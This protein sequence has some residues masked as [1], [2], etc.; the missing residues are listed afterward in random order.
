MQR[1]KGLEPK[2][3]RAFTLIELLVVIAIIAIL[4]AILFPVFAQARAKAR[5][6]SCLSNLRQIGTATNMYVQDYD[7][8]LPAGWGQ[9]GDPNVPD[10][11]QVW[12]V[13]LQPYIQ[14]VAGGNKDVYAGTKSASIFRCPDQQTEAPTNYGYNTDELVTGWNETSPGSGKWNSSGKA[15]AALNRPANLVAYADSGGEINKQPQSLSAD[16]NIRQGGGICNNFRTNNGLNATGDCGP[17][18]FNPTVWKEGWSCDWNFGVAGRGGDWATN[19]DYGWRRPMPRH[20]GFINA[21][22]ADGHAKALNA[23]TLK[24]KL[25]TEADVWHDHD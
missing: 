4:A 25:G 24:A 13:S 5:A 7:E 6:I 9:S 16:P 10:G 22:F 15:L 21:V 12:R 11:A 20:N 18:T 19:N 1:S 17:Y 3:I 8:T 23:G 14:K 2:R